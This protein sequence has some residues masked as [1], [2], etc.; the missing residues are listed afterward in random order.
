MIVRLYE[1]DGGVAN[2]NLHLGT[3]PHRVDEVDLLER[4]ARNVVVAD[5]GDLALTFRAHEIK[6]LRV[7]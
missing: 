7:T 6:T 5:N 4:H 2:A 1:A 3:P